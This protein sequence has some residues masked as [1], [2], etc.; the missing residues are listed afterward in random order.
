METDTTPTKE[1]RL[2]GIAASPGIVE[3]KVHLY[4]R[5]DIPYEVRSLEGWE[6]SAEVDRFLSAIEKSKQEINAL[7]QEYVRNTGAIQ[8]G[9]IF[10]AHTL[11]LEDPQI[12]EKTISNIERTK[13]NAEYCFN[14]AIDNVIDMFNHMKN[15]FFRERLVDIIDIKRRILRN[16][17]DNQLCALSNLPEPV[18]VVGRDLGPSDTVS[19]DRRNVLAIVTDLGGYT[20]HS[21]IIARSMGIPAVVAL[22]DIS[23]RVKQ[24]QELIVDGI[25]GVVILHPEPETRAHYHAKR[26]EFFALGEALRQIK[27]QPAMTQDGFMI[28]LSANM[29]SIDEIEDVKENGARGVGLLRTEFLCLQRNEF[30]PEEEQYLL[31]SK[32]LEEIAPNPVIIRTYDLGGDKFP[33]LQNAGKEL[34]P[35]LGWRAIR[36]CLDHPAIF[37]AQLRA[38]LRAGLKGR[39]KIMLPFISSVNE[40]HD[41]RKIIEEARRELH[42]DG[43]PY[44]DDYELGIMVETPSAAICADVLAHEVDFFSIGTNDLTQYLL[45]VDRGNEKIAH[46]YDPLNPA[47]IRMIHTTIRAGHA[48]GIWVGVCGE[49]AADPLV[50]YLLL[51]LGVDELSISPIFVPDVKQLIRSIKFNEAHLAAQR[52]LKMQTATEVKAYLNAQMKN[53]VLK[54]V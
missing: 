12:I 30:P 31:Y 29:E 47:V 17:T 40:I 16:L 25:E 13:K 14:L 10:E 11:I 5:D 44:T 48:A 46:Y 3:G 1:I 32:V 33:M 42:R 45:A 21:V 38:I 36:F 34:N 4:F 51:G 39:V 52:V 2:S 8:E 19:M 35:F 37:K 41:A 15:A 27:D 50:A 53:I 22:A 9:M 43:V 7:R 20:S 24:D 6:I 26:Q 23:G 54:P 49:I 18:I 28:E